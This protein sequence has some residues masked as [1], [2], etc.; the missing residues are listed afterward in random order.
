MRQIELTKSLAHS[1][2]LLRKISMRNVERGD[3]ERGDVE[4]DESVN[5][6]HGFQEELQRI[7]PLACLF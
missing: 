2:H 4:R 1:S 7:L 3:V 5:Y 6:K